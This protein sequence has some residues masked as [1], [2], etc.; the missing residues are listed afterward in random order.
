M[1]LKSA[2][3]FPPEKLEKIHDLRRLVEDSPNLNVGKDDAFLSKF[4]SSKN[5]HV[6]RAYVALHHYYDF[7]AENPE[8]VAHHPIDHF[9]DEFLEVCARFIMPKPD[10]E[11]RPIL[12]I[13]LVDAF[14]KYPNYLIDSVEMDDI[15]FDSLL[16]LPQT[17]DN[18]I[19][20]IVDMTGFSRNFLAYISPRITRLV[21]RK[22]KVLP[23][24]KRY[25]HF[26]VGGT[27]ISILSTFLLPLLLKDFKENAFRH[28]GKNF[29]KLRSMIGYDNLPN[30]YG[31]PDC[32]TLDVNLL[33]NYIEKH[34]DYLFK[35]QSYHKKKRY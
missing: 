32:N 20:I 26:I 14:E 10:K 8:W 21:H 1:M 34:A 22:E 24:S 25:I 7:K 33:W 12:I 4:L 29:D 15:I 28:D 35:L 16:L 9:H 31:G 3:I 27:F 23:F 17:Q 30:V 6:E 13:K 19:T 2:L 11:G 5:W 18:G